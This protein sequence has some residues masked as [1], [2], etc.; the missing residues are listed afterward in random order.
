[1]IL[2]KLYELAKKSKFKLDGVEYTLERIDGMY[3][4]CLDTKG[5]LYH[6]AAF[7]EVEA[8]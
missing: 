5:K 4:R 3:S 8:M 6:F 7:T 2:N 1:M